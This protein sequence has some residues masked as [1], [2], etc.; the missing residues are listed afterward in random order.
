MQERPLERAFALAKTGQFKNKAQ[1]ARAMRLEGYSY[2]DL[3]YLEGV[4]LSRQIASVCA[5][6]HRSQ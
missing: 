5:S 2:A 4:S 1:I 6:A 3:A